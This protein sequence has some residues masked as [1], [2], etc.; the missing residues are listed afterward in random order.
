MISTIY[1]GTRDPSAQ[2]GFINPRFLSKIYLSARDWWW[3]MKQWQ[4]CIRAAYYYQRCKYVA[5]LFK[6]SDDSS[7]FPNGYHFAFTI[8]DVNASWTNY[9]DS[10]VHCSTSLITDRISRERRNISLG[11]VGSLVRDISS[12]HNVTYDISGVPC[13]ANSGITNP[14]HMNVLFQEKQ[15]FA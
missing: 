5:L 15:F 7:C 10:M 12:S 4:F 9:T 14:R 1:D 2:T 6:C 3:I 11:Y 13:R 8:S